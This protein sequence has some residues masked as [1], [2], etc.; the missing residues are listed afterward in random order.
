[1]AANA[2]PMTAPG[3][4]ALVGLSPA[5]VAARVASGRTNRAAVGPSRTVAQILRAN[6]FTRFNAILAALLAVIAVV[7]PFQDALFG[8]VLVANAS[9]GLEVDES[10]LTGEGDP[11]AKEAGN[12]LLSGSFV[13][14]GTGWYRATCVGPDAYAARLAT[15]A[16][17]FA[18]VYSELRAGTDRRISC[19]R[20]PPP[21]WPTSPTRASLSR[22]FPVTT[23][24]RS[25]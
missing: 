18:L 14:A 5:D 10:L 8:M 23:P 15:E 6:L 1:M 17:R 7:G 11:V 20:K 19:G 4:G 13:V 2:P 21:P 22:S 16:R 3:R 25:R 24:E 12:E 9:N